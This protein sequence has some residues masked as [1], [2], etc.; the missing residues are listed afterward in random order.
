MWLSAGPPDL[1]QTALGL[2]FKSP[3]N[4][5]PFKTTLLSSDSSTGQWGQSPRIRLNWLPL[6]PESLGESLWVK[7][8]IQPSWVTIPMI[9]VSFISF[10]SKQF[11]TI[12]LLID[13]VIV[14]VYWTHRTLLILIEQSTIQINTSTHGGCPQ[15]P[16]HADGC[17]EQ[18]GRFYKRERRAAFKKCHPNTMKSRQQTQWTG[19]PEGPSDFWLPWH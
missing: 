11:Y 12:S 18:W 8:T 15:R 7:R 5:D 19:F 3:G 4:W 9:K 1:S 17:P 16:G 10:F 13:W 6:R 14:H 2:I